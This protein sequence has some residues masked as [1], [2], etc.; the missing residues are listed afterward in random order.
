MSHPQQRPPAYSDSLWH[1]HPH[2]PAASAAQQQYYYHHQTSIGDSAKDRQ[3][4]VQ[5]SI[6]RMQQQII[7]LQNAR[8]HD[9]SELEQLR[10]HCHKQSAFIDKMQADI[11]CEQALNQSFRVDA[12]KKL[13]ILVNGEIQRQ[14]SMHDLSCF[15]ALMLT[16]CHSLEQR[17]RLNEHQR[18]KLEAAFRYQNEPTLGTIE[19][20]NTHTAHARL[21]ISDIKTRIHENLK[22]LL[23]MVGKATQEHFGCNLV[24]ALNGK[25]M[26]DS[27]ALPQSV[28]QENA[29]MASE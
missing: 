12:I 6:A 5:Q 16:Y 20:Y 7:E 3:P 13:E 19:R 23:P 29:V 2:V 28:Q 27:R 25:P 9:R 11:A 8:Y 1:N 18:L 26:V 24:S 17:V 15:N 22:D 10:E 4:T 14:V 21:N